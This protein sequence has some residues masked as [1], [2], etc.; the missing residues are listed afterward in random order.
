V[1][2][3]EGFGATYRCYFG[4]QELITAALGGWKT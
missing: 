2:D 1:D 4:H 3:A